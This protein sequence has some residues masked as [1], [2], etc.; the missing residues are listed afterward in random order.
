MKLGFSVETLLP[1]ARVSGPLRMGLVRLAEDEWLQ[2]EPDLVER[3]AHFDRYPDSVIVQPEAQ[4][5]GE[6]LAEMLGL[7]GGL[8]AAARAAWED[9]C[10]LTR[11]SPEEPLLL[12][13]GALAFPTD[14]CLAD[15]IG[16]PLLE[17]HAPIHGYAGQLSAG[18]DSFMDGLQAGALF[19]RAN[20]FVVASDAL[21]YLPVDPPE[22]RFA[23]VTPQNAGET[24]F[25]RCERQ[26][27][28][29]LPRTGAILFTIGVY[30]A[31]L[32]TLCDAAVAR[33]AQ[34]LGGYEDGEGERRA[35][36]HYAEA[37][38]GYAVARNEAVPMA[39]AQGVR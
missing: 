9:F 26:T 20:A 23:H 29:R 33:I 16:K 3:N 17:V 19:G 12:T 21:R 1:S 11:A 22:A 28:R 25:V 30:R 32:G 10:L 35:A 4:A 18:V 7:E 8:E 13:G 38:A 6:E 36:P 37:L 5:A 24:L 39:V 2:P 27:L 31:A 34:S 15:K 14:W